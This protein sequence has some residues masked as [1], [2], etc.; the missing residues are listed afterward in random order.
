MVANT[1]NQ[2]RQPESILDANERN[3]LVNELL[4]FG[5]PIA[6]SQQIV[7]ANQTRRQIAKRARGLFRDLPKA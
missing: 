4:T 1:P 6:L 3:E 2:D 7:T 5:L